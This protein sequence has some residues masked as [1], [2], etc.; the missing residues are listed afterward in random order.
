MLLT[1]RLRGRCSEGLEVPRRTMIMPVLSLPFGPHLSKAH[2][3][4]VELRALF[5][6]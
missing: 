5:R 2:L 6:L 3:L 1:G 4:D